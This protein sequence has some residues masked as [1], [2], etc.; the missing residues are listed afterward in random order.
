MRKL[1]AIIMIIFVCTMFYTCSSDTD[2]FVLPMESPDTSLILQNFSTSRLL[3][4]S[5]GDTCLIT[6]MVV[7]A[8]GTGVEGIKVIFETSAFVPESG[9]VTY[10]D[11]LTYALSDSLGGVLAYYTS[12][13]TNYGN[14]QIFARTGAI[15]D[16]LTLTVIPI[17]TSIQ[18]TTNKSRIL[19]DGESTVQ[20]NLRPISTAGNVFD[21]S[22]YLTSD[23]GLLNESIVTTDSS[24]FAYGVLHSIPSS[25]DISTVIRCWVVNNPAKRDS[26]SIIFAGITVQL[27]PDSNYI[28]SAIDSTRVVAFVHETTTLNPVPDKIVSWTT[29]LG[30]IGDPSVTNVDGEAYTTL[31]STGLSGAAQ[32]TGDIGNG[33][34]GTTPVII[35]HG[36]ADNIALSA[37]STSIL[38]N[39]TRFATISAFVGDDAG[40]AMEGIGVSIVHSLGTITTTY[41]VTNINGIASF[42][43]ISPV[44]NLDLNTTL[45]GSVV[46]NSGISD[47]IDIQ[48]RGISITVVPP[49][50][51]SLISDG[52]STLTI[53]ANIFETT[54]QSPVSSESVQ[55]TTTL[56]TINSPTLSDIQGNTQSVL[57]SVADLTGTALV[58]AYVGNMQIFST[59]QINLITLDVTSLSLE[60]QFTSI[61]GDGLATDTLTVTTFDDLG[62]TVPAANIRFTTDAGLFSNNQ[63]EIYKFTDAAGISKAL[64][65]SQ[66]G[67]SDLP[68]HVTVSSVENPSLSVTSNI[69]FRGITITVN[70]AESE[71]IANGYSTTLITAQVKE[72]TNGNPLVGKTVNWATNLG[73]IESSSITS[74]TGSATTTLYSQ[75]DQVGTATVTAGYGL[76]NPGSVTVVILPQPN[77][78]YLSLSSQPGGSSGGQSTLILNAILTDSESHPIMNYSVDFTILQTGI[79]SLSP[80]SDLTDGTGMATAQFT[81]PFENSGSNVTFRATAGSLQT[82]LQVTL[83]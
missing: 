30:D 4:E 12:P 41:G 69:T 68:A 27:T 60:P 33:L 82:P 22:L 44:S 47:S 65:R 72:T 11:G 18:L 37:S 26:V 36:G 31:T 42:E 62:G 59:T 24:G 9:I 14:F 16:S 80:S 17:I 35:V 2:S 53:H 74:S 23:Y 56:G 3:V 57:H 81:Y 5:G 19:S 8:A 73:V 43:L 15:T 54:L 64:L 39:G 32:I 67:M 75:V 48:F 46:G 20:L 40:N 77:P 29:T 70:S 10:P 66:P 61:L 71:I 21:L 76:L 45:S 51:N 25:S 78:G 58:R 63:Q 6:A 49:V 34:V 38:A 7:N 83:P 50:P 13:A 55:W 1:S 28:Q 52:V 79:G